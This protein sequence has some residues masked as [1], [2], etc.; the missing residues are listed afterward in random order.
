MGREVRRVPKNWEHPKKA[1]GKNYKPLFGG[2]VSA[3]QEDWDIGK[4]KWE[5][6]FRENF[7]SKEWV[8][9]E[10]DETHTWEEWTGKRPDPADYM[11][12]WKPEERTHYQ[13]YENTSEGT[14]ISPVCESPEE[15]A[16]WLTDT[17]ASAFADMTASY[18]QWLS[19][20]KGRYAPSAV[21]TV[22]GEVG[23]MQSGVAAVGDHD[24][25][26]KKKS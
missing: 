2:S 20:C 17:K 3:M 4:A 18:E 24:Q 7:S 14:P 1:D 5:E 22:R 19:V 23:V 26:V 13:M 11:P 21:I 25:E 9:R 8:P 10:P 15:L 16:R 12:D 6:G